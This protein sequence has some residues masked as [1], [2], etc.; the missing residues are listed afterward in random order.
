MRRRD[1]LE[2]CRRYRRYLL[3]GVA[4]VVLVIYLRIFMFPTKTSDLEDGA[5][6]A[7]FEHQ[8]RPYLKEVADGDT[9]IQYFPFTGMYHH[10]QWLPFVGNGHFAVSLV[11]PER[12]LIKHPQSDG[13]VNSGINPLLKVAL[14]R[15]YSSALGAYVTRFTK[16]V[17][18]KIEC[19]SFS[20]VAS[21][22]LAREDKSWKSRLVKAAY[23]SLKVRRAMSIYDGFAPSSTGNVGFTI[24]F[25]DFATTFNVAPGKSERLQFITAIVPHGSV[26]GTRSP[27]S[28]AI[29]KM[30]NSAVSIAMEQSYKEH[31]KAWQ[32]LWISGFS[33]AHS[34]AP[35][36][37]NGDLINATIYYLL[38]SYPLRS[39]KVN[40][41]APISARPHHCYSSHT[42]LLY[43][44][45]L[46]S[47]LDSIDSILSTVSRWNFTL[48][49]HG[50]ES[51]VFSG[52]A[53]LMQA[54]ILSF[55]AFKHTAHHLEFDQQPRELHRHILTDCLFRN[56]QFV[57]GV[58]VNIW[59]QVNADDKAVLYVNVNRTETNGNALLACDAGCLDNPIEL[60]ADRS[61]IPLKLTDPPTPILYITDDRSHFDY[62]KMSIHVREVAE[63]PAHEHHVIALHK[64]GHRLGG[65]PTIFWLTL[66][67]LLVIF[68]L[69]LLKLIYNEYKGGAS[70]KAYTAFRYSAKR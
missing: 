31:L 13:F 2:F 30:A 12:L 1:V 45:Q 38:S 14:N 27:T 22:S 53:G 59:V 7:I 28:D 47:S 42:T 41:N 20:E 49:E 3:A 11:Q 21:F 63:A 36:S 5:C 66:G 55:G 10:S 39:N 64:H 24:M 15:R 67:V 35:A 65:L 29:L 44:S 40:H 32:Q 25:Q 8:I 23:S 58:A 26:N 61:M 6:F 46:W 62:L 48:V 52:A 43:P 18:E 17:V 50:C 9:A 69:F 33:I 51:L 56:V 70:R 34:R 54:V 4:A 57:K 16:G 19:F 37:I 60:R 68:H